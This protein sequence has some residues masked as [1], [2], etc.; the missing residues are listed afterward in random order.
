MNMIGEIRINEKYAHLYRSQYGKTFK[1]ESTPMVNKKVLLTNDYLRRIT[2]GFKTNDASILP[3]NCRYIQKYNKGHIVVV[4]EPPAF[5]TVHMSLNF[6]D[7]IRQLTE[8]GKLEEYGYDNMFGYD[9]KT[10]SL[11]LALPYV[12]FI[13]YVNNYNELSAGQVFFRVARLTG[14]SDYLLKAPF[15]NISDNQYICFGSRVNGQSQT[16]NASIEKTINAFWSAQFNTDYTY[17]RKAYKNVAGIRSYMEWQALS[18]IDPMFIYNVN[19]IKIP[20][21]VGQAVTEIQRHYKL[22][23][24]NDFQYKTLSEIFAKPLDTGID[25]KPNPRA[26]KKF[27]LFYD[28]A[29]GVH[30]DSRFFLHVGDPFYI[31]NDK[32]LCHVNSF[33]SFIDSGDIKY[34]RVEREDGKLITYKYTRKFSEYISREAKK[35]RYESTGTLKNGVTIKENDILILKTPAGHELYK[36]VEYIRKAR[37]GV[38]EGRF[39]DG[40]YILENTEAKVLDVKTPEINGIELNKKD[41]YIYTTAMSELPILSCAVTN[42]DGIDTGP[43]GSL[44]INLNHIDKTL[45][46]NP[47]QVRMS[48]TPNQTKKI[49]SMDEVK[50]LP[51]VFRIGRTLRA[52][53][54]KSD[55]NTVANDNT[56]VFGSER[57]ILFDSVVCELRKP[58][59]QDIRNHILVEDKFRI[60]SFDMDIAFDIGDKVVVSDWVNPVNMLSVKVI[61]AFKFNESSGN[62]TFILADRDGNLHQEK[63]VDGQNGFIY[64]GR[65][66]KITNT[67]GKLTAGTKIK[68]KEAGIPHFPMK[69][70]NIIIGF[71][72]DTDGPDPLVLCSNCC[73]LWY[74]DVLSKFQKITMKAKKWASLKHAP[75][76]VSKIKYQAG[77][78]VQGESVNRNNSGWMTFKVNGSNILKYMDFNHYTAY[79]DYYSLDRYIMAH[80][81]LDCIP[82]PR[83][84]A[85]KQSETGYVKAWPNFHGHFFTS[86]VPVLKFINDERSIVNVQSSSE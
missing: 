72:T 52:A 42:Y 49:F 5:R 26:R 67:F 80:S 62:I 77:D 64:V 16:L 28:A 60:Q 54:S 7:E 17:N 50:P 81:R 38:H 47:Y 82:N 68:C 27:R 66:R 76:D 40:F 24:N 19:W 65:I 35:L 12:I 78:L 41:T 63:Y 23:T 21:S 73:T 10:E 14:M 43:Q 34:I 30:I 57:G 86:P 25:E 75:I 61:Q 59:V 45:R 55:G 48:N 79:P 22:S 71:I 29:E 46:P 3:P 33:I 32:Q 56:T 4:E 53:R 6:H 39:G 31:K 51:P 9:Y 58:Q 8:E 2:S 74:S 44:F 13:L 70:V 85:K 36:K 20:M 69:D 15:T 11:T 84:G 1:G 83:I 18:R 37:E